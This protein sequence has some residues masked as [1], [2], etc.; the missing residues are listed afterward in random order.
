M[1]SQTNN[2]KGKYFIL[3]DTLLIDFPDIE[4][5]IF[6]NNHID[7]INEIN[8]EYGEKI[9][10]I[11]FA[12]ETFDSLK[13]EKRENQL[14]K[15]FPRSKKEIIKFAKPLKEKN[16]FISPTFPVQI[17]EDISIISSMGLAVDLIHIID[18]LDFKLTLNLLDYYLHNASLNVP[19][20]PFHTILVSKL[21]RSTQTLWNMNLRNP[22]QFYH[23]DETGLSE[24]PETLN[25]A[26][27]Q[28]LIDH[29][30]KTFKRSTQNSPLQS[31]FN[32]LPKAR[33]KCMACPHFHIC[34][35]W[36]LYNKDSCQK[37][38]KCLTTL[39]EAFRELKALEKFDQEHT[40]IKPPSH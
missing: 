32:S 1:S 39:Q 16:F 7:T 26:Q 38:K 23:C 36:A 37:W 9:K 12:G 6:I 34:I 33:P 30:A 11:H 5:I 2:F 15:I 28:Y 25:N 24:S 4:K 21:H 40:I 31:Y 14:I 10:Q 8:Q 27:Y 17:L 35:A 22:D 18:T 29:Q 13:I 20:E 19:I 3:K